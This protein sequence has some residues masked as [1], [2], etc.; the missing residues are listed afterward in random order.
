MLHFLS[1]E[2][3]DARKE[4]LSHNG[5]AMFDK[6]RDGM[7]FC[8]QIRRLVRGVDRQNIDGAGSDDIFY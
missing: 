1:E 3:T 5:E 7:G 2:E 8:H 6:Q 4:L